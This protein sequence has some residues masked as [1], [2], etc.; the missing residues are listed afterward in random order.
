[1]REVDC[2]SERKKLASL[3]GFFLRCSG[4]FGRRINRSVRSG[5]GDRRCSISQIAPKFADLGVGAAANRRV[6]CPNFCKL[7]P[8]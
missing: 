1:M 4:K 8:L 5:P 2:T 7:L 3:S 6:L